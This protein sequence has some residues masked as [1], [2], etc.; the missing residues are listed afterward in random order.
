MVSVSVLDSGRLPAWM[1][2]MSNAPRIARRRLSR[3]VAGLKSGHKPNGYRY[4]E[5]GEF[6]ARRDL[7]GNPSIEVVSTRTLH[8]FEDPSEML[9]L[10]A[11]VQEELAGSENEIGDSFEITDAHFASDDEVRLYQESWFD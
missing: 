4:P 10:E 8:H 2:V 3:Q 7:I 9:V 5:T 11:W 6:R 1:G